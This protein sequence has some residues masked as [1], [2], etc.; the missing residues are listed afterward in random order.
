MKPAQLISSL[1]LAATSNSRGLHGRSQLKGEEMIPGAKH[2][3]LEHLAEW[4]E[5]RQGAGILA[6]FFAHYSN[7]QL[8]FVV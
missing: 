2:S 6:R 8:M 3:T 4:T 1:L 7:I 5:G